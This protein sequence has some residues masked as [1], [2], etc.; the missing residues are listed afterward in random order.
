T[1]SCSGEV[2]ERWWNSPDPHRTF[3]TFSA[4]TQSLSVAQVEQFHFLRCCQPPCTVV[5][6]INC[7]RVGEA[8]CKLERKQRGVSRI[9]SILSILS[10]P[11]GT[12]YYP[13]YGSESNTVR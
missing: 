1:L 4:L 12:D 11:L 3:P 5:Q 2:D 9:P 13:Q 10:T 8:R 7:S 6:A